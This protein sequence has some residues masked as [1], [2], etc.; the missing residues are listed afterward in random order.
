MSNSQEKRDLLII[1][2]LLS[3]L[4]K[5]NISLEFIDFELNNLLIKISQYDL[6]NK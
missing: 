1:E 4:D 5:Y 2:D 6:L 3:L